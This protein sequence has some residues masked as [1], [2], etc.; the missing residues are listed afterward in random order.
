M[1]K[2]QK[3][4]KNDY[5]FIFMYFAISS[6]IL[7]LV[8]FDKRQQISS[9]FTETPFN[10][11]FSHLKDT[12]Y[13]DKN[14]NSKTA[15][16]YVY[17]PI[18]SINQT[19]DKGLSKKT[20]SY[21][22][23]LSEIN[24]VPK[25]V[26]TRI[27]RVKVSIQNHYELKKDAKLLSLKFQEFKHSEFKLNY[28][29]AFDEF[30]NYQDFGNEN[31]LNIHLPNGKLNL[32]IRAVNFKHKLVTKYYKISIHSKTPFTKKPWFW[33]IMTL[34]ALFPF[35]FYYFR[36]KLNRQKF[37]FEQQLALEK[38]RSKITADL[39]DE[40][41]SSL[42]SLQINSAVATFL[43]ENNPTEAQKILAK[44]EAQSESLSA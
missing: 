42:S 18:Q 25:L 24:F 31:T 28:Q 11:D 43:L 26:E 35:I 23:Y 27:N 19:I 34:L 21:K 20:K 40:I 32:Y 2:T 37:L 1:Q 22:F 38:Q 16:P 17:Q 44:I 6:F 9:N 29:F 10:D 14:Y 30:G 3:L 39:H 15:I 12:V 41:G 4:T 36:L 13:I 5:F 33:P 7:G 8:Y